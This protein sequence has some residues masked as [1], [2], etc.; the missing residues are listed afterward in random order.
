VEKIPENLF[1]LEAGV[2]V[3]GTPLEYSNGYESKILP[4]SLAI[5]AISHK[6]T[7]SEGREKLIKMADGLDLRNNDGQTPVREACLSGQKAVLR[8]LLGREE[9]HPQKIEKA[10]RARLLDT[11]RAEHK[12][13]VQI[14]Y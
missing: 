10:G 8:V 9:V 13:V 4:V 7:L 5:D 12:G 11:A 3:L 1:E 2:M 6:L 14:L